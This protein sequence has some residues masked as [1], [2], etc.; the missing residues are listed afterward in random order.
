MLW[1]GLLRSRQRRL[2]HH[3]PQ[4]LGI[5]KFQQATIGISDARIWSLTI[6]AVGWMT[7]ICLRIVAPSLV[8]RTLPLGSWIWIRFV[9]SKGIWSI[10][11][12]LGANSRTYHL[13]HSAGAETRPDNIC[14]SYEKGV[15]VMQGVCAYLWRRWCWWTWCLWSSRNRDCWLGQFWPTLH[16]FEFRLVLL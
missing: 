15:L 10:R 13:V 1:G 16:S 9:I 4:Y 3:Q 7:S 6:F 5:S 14:H 2:Y 12:C 11:P 8:I